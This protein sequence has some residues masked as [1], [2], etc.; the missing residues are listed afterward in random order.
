LIDQTILAQSRF[1]HDWVEDNVIYFKLQYPQAE[2]KVLRSILSDIAAEHME[3]HNAYLHNDYQD[4]MRIKTDLLKLYDWYYKNRPIAAG[5]G[6]FFYNQD[7]RKSPIQN[8][9]DGR[10]A[11]RKEYQKIRDT[12]IGPNGDT[13]SYEYQYYEMMQ[14]EAKV[15]INAIYGAF[16]AKTFQLYNVYTAASTTGTAQSLISTTAMAFEAF[17]NNAVKFKSL[18]ELVTLVGNVLVK[19]KRNL[20]INGLTPITDP[21]IV[22]KLWKSQFLD[23]KESYEPT[24]RNLLRNRDVEDLTRLYYINNLFAFVENDMIKSRLIRIYDVTTAFRNPNEIPDNIKEDLEFIWD[25]CREFVF[26]NH[27]YTEQ[28]DRL[29]HD[30]RTRVILIDTDSNVINIKPWVDWTKDNV[31]NHS[32]SSMG[33]EDMQFCSVNILAY[34]VTR[35]A[36]ELLDR[37][38]DDCNVLPRFHKRLNTKNEF[39]FPKVLLANVKKRYIADIRLREGKQVHKIELK[40][41]DFKKAGVNANIEKELMKII[42]ND[43]I[44]DPLVNVVQLMT[45]VARLERQIRESIKNRERTYLVRMNCKVAKSYKDPYSQGAFTGPLLWNLINPDNVIMVPDKCDVVFIN[46]PN[47]KVLDEKLAPYFPKEADIIRKNIFHGGI[48]QFEQKGVSYLALPNDDSKIP[49]WVYPV[50]DEERIVT[51]NSGTFY[52][53][54]KALTFITISAGDNEYSSNILNV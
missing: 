41:H 42:K 46:I 24:I 49:E 17:L 26:Y 37:Y 5:D 18:G 20:S 48:P 7:I 28:I 32:V 39:Y 35:M 51:R 50:I 44:D 54:L 2:E 27:A 3:I 53:V 4:D 10:I 1:F 45:D 31:W 13:T 40:G 33:E 36:R 6:T 19:D 38:A 15:K 52:P 30:P 34:L 11:A 16:G 29:K 14:M 43:I 21:E 22:Y 47:E 23:Y 12:Y 9:I 8:V 25:Y